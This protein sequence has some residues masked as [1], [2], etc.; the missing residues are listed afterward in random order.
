MDRGKKNMIQ[1]KE[2]SEIPFI[3]MLAKSKER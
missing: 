3:L 2:L 1:I